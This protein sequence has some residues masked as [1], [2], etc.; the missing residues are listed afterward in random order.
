MDEVEDEDK[1]EDE[2]EDEDKDN[3]LQPTKEAIKIHANE[4]CY[5]TKSAPLKSASLITQI[6][7]NSLTGGPLYSST[8]SLPT[9]QLSAKV[10]RKG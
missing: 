8:P 5:P 3:N 1:E 9:S 10:R 7:T 2:D 6:K 4:I